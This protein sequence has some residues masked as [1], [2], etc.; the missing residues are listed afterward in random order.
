MKETEEQKEII[1]RSVGD[2]LKNYSCERQNLIP[3]L[4]DVQEKFGYL[5]VMAMEII[6]DAFGIPAVDVYGPARFFNRFR[7]NPAGKN[8]I[9]V[10]MGTACYMAGGEFA[11]ESFERR[12]SIKEGETTPDG[13]FSLERVACVGCCSL[14]P[15]VVVNDL[16]E[17]HVT[18]T[19]VDGLLLPFGIGEEKEEKNREREDKRNLRK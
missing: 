1:Y 4:Q 5:P 7:L 11:L 17:G 6:A 19:R 9:K 10:C 3:V 16:V 8:Q 15:V 13:E 2:I 14:A 18:P 12:L